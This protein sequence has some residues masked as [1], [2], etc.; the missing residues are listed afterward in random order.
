LKGTLALYESVKQADIAAIQ[1]I[2]PAAKTLL[3]HFTPWLI[4]AE[5]LVF[6]LRQFE[7]KAV[8]AHQAQSLTIPVHYQ[9][10]DLNEVAA[11]LGIAT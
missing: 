5:E 11:L 2:V 9:G 3:I 6:Q 10:E 4:P 1:D 7:V 8:S